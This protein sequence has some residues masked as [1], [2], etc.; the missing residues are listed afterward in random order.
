MRC[1]FLELSIK[2]GVEVSRVGNHPTGFGDVD[3]GIAQFEAVYERFDEERDF[4][5]GI[6][7]E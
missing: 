5:R 7:Q 2:L 3:L 1:D 6:A 4:L